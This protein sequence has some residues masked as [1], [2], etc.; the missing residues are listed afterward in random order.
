L[1]STTQKK[2][3]RTA[4]RIARDEQALAV[5][6]L[7]ERK[8]QTRRKIEWGGLVAKSGL[9]EYPKSVMLGAMLAL[10]EQLENDV[11]TYHL[12]EM[13]GEAAFLGYLNDGDT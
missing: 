12:F 8:A 2:I 9:S 13:K 6:R 4:Q 1:D 11:D 7:K 5:L 10:A 3:V